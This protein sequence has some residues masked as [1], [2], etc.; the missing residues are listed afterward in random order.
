[1]PES[2]FP[3]PHVEQLSYDTQRQ[4]GRDVVV[5]A[6]A[7]STGRKCSGIGWDSTLFCKCARGWHP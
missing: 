4:V 5:V 3:V 2:H 1:V 6:K 7:R